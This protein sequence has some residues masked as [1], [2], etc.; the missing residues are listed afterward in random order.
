[1]YVCGALL[2]CSFFVSLAVYDN[3]KYSIT[4]IF[5]TMMAR[6]GSSRT[7]IYTYIMYLSRV[8]TSIAASG[9]TDAPRRQPPC[10]A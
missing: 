2:V 7:H 5:V 8:H 1:M 9:R 3:L 6:D 10:G 4:Y